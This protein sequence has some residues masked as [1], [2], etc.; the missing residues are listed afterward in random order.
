MRIAIVT[1]L[2]MTPAITTV[3]LAQDGTGHGPPKTVI[4]TSPTLPTM[5]VPT[6][7]TGGSLSKLFQ[8][9]VKLG[10]MTK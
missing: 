5:P 1:L 6:T 2:V 9:N 8:P 10:S 7:G 4:V 3:A